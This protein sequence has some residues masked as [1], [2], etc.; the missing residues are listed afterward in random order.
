MPVSGG[1][2]G[3]FC[4]LSFMCTPE[5]SCGRKPALSEC[6]GEAHGC[7]EECFVG[8]CLESKYLGVFGMCGS[9][10]EFGGR[11]STPEV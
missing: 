3:L 1:G 10:C 7:C 4:F 5:F 2:G 8:E 6:G 11:L 9:A